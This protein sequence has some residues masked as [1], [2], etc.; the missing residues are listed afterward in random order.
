MSETCL[1]WSIRMPLKRSPS[2]SEV[3]NECE[4]VSDFMFGPIK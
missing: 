1:D 4:G 3:G 2:L